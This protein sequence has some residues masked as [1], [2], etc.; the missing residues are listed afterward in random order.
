M[1]QKLIPI[2][3][4]VLLI[5]AGAAP[6]DATDSTKS[7]TSKAPTRRQAV[8]KA[9]TKPQKLVLRSFSV[10]VEDQKDR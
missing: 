8:V 3:L 6:L 4:G 9:P 7:K 1:F 10:L 2:I 5:A